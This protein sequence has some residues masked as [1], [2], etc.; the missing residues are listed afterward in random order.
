VNAPWFEVWADA[1][2][3]PPYLLLTMPDKAKGIFVVLDPQDGGKQVFA[4]ESYD[5]LRLWLLEDEYDK[6]L[7][8]M[9]NE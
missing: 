8:R 3:E 2:L 1:G 5:E 4:A 9:S 6:V 7:G